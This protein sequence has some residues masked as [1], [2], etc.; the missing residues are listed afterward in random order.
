MAKTFEERALEINP[1]Y[2]HFID[3]KE[4][5]KAKEAAEKE[6]RN[7]EK[8]EE[9]KVVLTKTDDVFI[10]PAGYK[11]YM[12]ADGGTLYLPSMIKPEIFPNNENTQTKN[13]KINISLIKGSVR[14]FNIDE[15]RY[16][17]SYN[18]EGKFVGY[19][20]FSDNS[21]YIS[22]SPL[23]STGTV[24]KYS[25]GETSGLYP[26]E[27]V[28]NPTNDE[29]YNP[30]KWDYDISLKLLEARAAI[31]LIATR[32]KELHSN[33]PANTGLEKTITPWHITVNFPTVDKA[34]KDDA[35]VKYF[36]LSPDINAK[37]TGLDYTLYDVTIVKS[38]GP[39][40]NIG[41]GDVKKGPVYIL[42]YKAVLKK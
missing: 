38:Y 6:A 14:S 17:A 11:Q 2:Q 4:R 9:S 39:F 8:A 3:S 30:E 27:N 10:P 12:S 1:L 41:G 35:D 24:S 31:H 16:V 5:K 36:Y 25:F 26:L 21:Y 37:H 13:T 15:S 29:I 32:N 22:P 42:F 34:I 28:N 23:S 18:N 33:T 19:I 7:A 40:Y 20:N